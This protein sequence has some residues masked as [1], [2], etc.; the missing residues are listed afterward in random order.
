[1]VLDVENN[2][3]ILNCTG[4]YKGRYVLGPRDSR[5]LV[6]STD[7]EF[8]EKEYYR[9][10]ELDGTEE[11][12]LASCKKNR[13]FDIVD[14]HPRYNQTAHS[15]AKKMRD[16]MDKLDY[17][18][19]LILHIVVDSFSRR[20]FYRKLNE[21]VEFLTSTNT[22][23]VHGVFDFKIHN[24]QGQSSIENMVA[25]LSGIGKTKRSTKGSIYSED[26]WNKLKEL[27]YM[28]YIGQENCNVNFAPTF[29][30][31]IPLDHSVNEFYC[32]AEK[33][34]DYNTQKEKLGQHRCIGKAMSHTYILNY[35]WEYLE[36]YPDVDKWMYLHL[37][38]AHEGTGQHGKTLDSD[39]R[40]FLDK[41][42]KRN[43][44]VFVFLEAD[45]GMRYG[46]WKRSEAASYEWKLPAFFLILPHEFLKTVYNSYTTLI[47]NTTRL[48]TK[49][50]VRKTLLD[51]A[52]R[53]K[54]KRA[55]KKL[56]PEEIVLYND[57]IPK[58]RT[59]RDVQIPSIYCSCLNFQTI[60][61]E[62]Y[63]YG[64]HTDPNFTELS[65]LIN[66]LAEDAVNYMNEE[67]FKKVHMNK[68]CKVLSLRNVSFGSGYKT[69]KKEL[70]KIEIEVNEEMHARYEALYVITERKI[71]SSMYEIP[72]RDILYRSFKRSY[73]ML[74]INRVDSYAGQ[75]EKLALYLNL[76]AKMCI[77]KENVPKTLYDAVLL[78]NQ[79]S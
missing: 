23:G 46:D 28:T 21:T 5:K 40:Q 17:K 61:S 38:A 30:E 41:V 1:M 19:T 43:E 10:V 48:S 75:C 7:L 36:K 35:S 44:S 54:S 31:Y 53:S 18:P 59:C 12:V 52:Y 76:D 32:A 42:L 69:V 79:E 14:M 4:G 64:I 70:I 34:S 29:G 58:F 27:G 67:L 8:N 60:D 65:R 57:S 16:M 26:L 47:I 56:D 22:Q 49:K 3:M 15:N 20:H 6:I 50:D 51:I 72:S 33:Y 45:H 63:N 77:C 25:T 73:T 37:N 9:P 55:P 2:V 11:Y 13:K 24:I 39:L 62:V 74:Y 68:L 66:I 78:H 71:K